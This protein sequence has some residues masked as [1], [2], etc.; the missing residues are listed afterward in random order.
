MALLTIRTQDDTILAKPSRVVTAFDGRLH[1]L[2]DDMKETLAAAGGVGLAAPQVGVLRRVCVIDTE[3]TGYL[4]LVNPEITALFGSEEMPEGCLSIPGLYGYVE[5]PLCVT[6]R[7]QDRHGQE[8]QH[9]A[10][11]FSA[12][13]FCHEIDHLE[14]L[15]FTRLVSR[16]YEPEEETP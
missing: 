1:T 15:L 5:R 13:A 6:V 3:D 10:E 16:W 9:I 11:G 8:T 12:R 14:G 4:E 7:A 2:L